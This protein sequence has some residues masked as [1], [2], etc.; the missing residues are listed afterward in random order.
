MSTQRPSFV[1]REREMKLKDKARAK[2]E[3][4]AARRAEPRTG[5]GPPIATDEA[6]GEAAGVTTANSDT[7]PDASSASAITPPPGRPR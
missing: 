2:A 4:R 5:H 1:K 7:G 6:A 3:R